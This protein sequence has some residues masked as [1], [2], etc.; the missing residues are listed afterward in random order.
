M[1]KVLFTFRLKEYLQESLIEKFPEVHFIFAESPEQ[2][3][4]ET[5]NII[6]TYGADLNPEIMDR[7]K[8]LE[9]IM[10][11][12][13]GVEQMPLAAVQEWGLF[14]TNARGIHKSPMAE[15]V[16][17]H[18]L[19]QKR[20]LPFIYEQQGKKEWS[21]KAVLTELNGSTAL[22]LGPGS[23]GAEIGRLLQAFGVYTIGCNRN[24]RV[25]EAMDEMIS[26][27]ELHS[28]LAEA[29]LIISVL[30]STAETKDLLTAD[31]FRAMKET[32][33]FM[34]FGRGDL[35]KEE[36]LLAALKNEE[37]SL[38]VLDVFESEPLSPENE[39]WSLSN[40]IISPHISSLSGKYNERVL[41]IFEVNLK[42]WL[43]GKRDLINLIDPSKG[44]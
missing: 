37:I 28:K 26:F 19:A 23:I 12:S 41:E 6:V 3:E 14:I 34:N 36:V 4:L 15:S 27:K 10:V 16:L 29:D 8:A 20:A 9:W 24:G 25:S 30:P 43:D 40:C 39:L 38:A 21:R 35:V 22:I 33:M 31:H 13:A 42:K 18:I 17:A 1:V 11:G 32:A 2:K 44:Y 5:A 7:A